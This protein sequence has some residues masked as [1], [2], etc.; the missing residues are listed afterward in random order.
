MTRTLSRRLQRLEER[1]ATAKAQ[2]PTHSHVIQFVDPERGVVSTL[3]W[4]N[5]RD[6]WTEPEDLDAGSQA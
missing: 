1:A 6:I 3:R 5:G 4:D 2:S